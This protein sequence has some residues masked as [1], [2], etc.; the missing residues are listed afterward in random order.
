MFS[1]SAKR[2]ID[3]NKGICLYDD[4]RGEEVRGF[5]VE[6]WKD[7][8]GSAEGKKKVIQQSNINLDLLE[9]ICCLVSSSS[10]FEYYSINEF[11]VAS[12]SSS[13]S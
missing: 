9:L 5:A 1:F 11:K 13:S 4:K 3:I 12:T 10:P 8:L 6:C 7:F 2:F